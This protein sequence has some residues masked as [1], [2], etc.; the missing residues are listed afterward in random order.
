MDTAPLPE[1]ITRESGG[2]TIEY[3]IVVATIVILL[4]AVGGPLVDAVGTFFSGIPA[5][6]PSP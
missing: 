4:V 6:F 5:L 2:V 1:D 3:G